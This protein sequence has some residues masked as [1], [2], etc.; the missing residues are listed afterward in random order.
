MS[1]ML[2]SRRAMVALSLGLSSALV[3]C[4]DTSGS[5]GGSSVQIQIYGEEA[6]SEGF[7]FPTG[8]EVAISDGWEIRFS[9]VLVVI[10]RAWLSEN[11]DTAPSDQSRTGDVVAEAK[12]PWAVDLHKKGDALAA[13]GGTGAIPL[14]V[15]EDQNQKGGAPLAS[16]ER[17]AFGYATAAAS[18][19]AKIVNFRDDTEALALYHEMMEKGYSIYYVG[20]ATWKGTDCQSSDP[21]YDFDA[22]PKTVDIKLGFASPSEYVNC[23]NQDNQGDPFE[24]EEYQRGVPIRDSR[25]S[26]AQMTF[27]LE[28]PLFSSV[29]HDSRLYFDQ[30]VAPLAGEASGTVTLESLAGLDPQGFTDGNGA[31]LPFRICDGSS[32][33]TVKQR[34]FETGSV[35]VDPK[36]SP[37]KALRD[38]RDFVMYVQS[39]QGHLN[40]GEGLCFTKR[41]YPSPP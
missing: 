12:G 19:A 36:A 39:T 13:G 15:I 10:D 3:G 29:V 41:R 8:S 31:D 22:L 25:P 28:H 23:Q 34:Y 11:P 37:A 6:A 21:S 4:G 24:G 16:G 1:K 26:V 38:Y 27:H 7:A 33:P 5:T 35:P 40:G 2:V 14:A 30:F 9:H 32:L 18:D 20:K 17:Y